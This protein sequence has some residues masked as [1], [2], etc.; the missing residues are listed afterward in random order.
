MYLSLEPCALIKLGL[1]GLLKQASQ[2]NICNRIR[3]KDTGKIH[4]EC[5]SMVCEIFFALGFP[6]DKLYVNTV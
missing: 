4:L 5:S 2:F 1:D 3:I 6:F